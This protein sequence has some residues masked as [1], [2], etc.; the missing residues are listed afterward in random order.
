[1]GGAGLTISGTG[2]SF[3]QDDT[4]IMISIDKVVNTHFMFFNY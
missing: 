2:V 3:L 1:M 4:K